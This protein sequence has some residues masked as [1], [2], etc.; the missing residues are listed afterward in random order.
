[1]AHWRVPKILR[2]PN[3]MEDAQNRTM[4]AGGAKQG[5]DF[6]GGGGI[7]HLGEVRRRAPDAA[8][9]T[10]PRSDIIMLSSFT[11]M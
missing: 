10:I 1:M 9:E 7:A 2:H 3:K 6:G 8:A 4:G 11:L 5:A